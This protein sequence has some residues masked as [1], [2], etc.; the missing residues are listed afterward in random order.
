MHPILLCTPREAGGHLRHCFPPN[1]SVRT[2]KGTDG[3][4]PWFR[5]KWGQPSEAAVD[6]QGKDRKDEPQLRRSQ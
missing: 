2:W 1:G 3:K 4:A 6:T 5:K